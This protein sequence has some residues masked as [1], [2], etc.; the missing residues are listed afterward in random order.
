MKKK[1]EKMKE[2]ERMVEFKP[3]TGMDPEG[4][5][6]ASGSSWYVDR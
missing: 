3:I 2:S 5:F 6:N 4:N 1:G